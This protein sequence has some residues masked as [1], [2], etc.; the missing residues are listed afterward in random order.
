MFR[1]LDRYVLR[2]FIGPFVLASL[3]AVGIYA[4]IET[5]EKLEDVLQNYSGFTEVVA[6]LSRYHLYRLPILMPKLAYAITMI[7]VA[8][9]LVRLARHNELLAMKALGLNLQ[10]VVLPLVVA[11]FVIALS[12]GVL[13]EAMLPHVAGKIRDTDMKGGSEDDPH[14]YRDVMVRDSRG[15]VLVVQTYHSKQ[16]EF[17]DAEWMEANR[18]ENQQ[19]VTRVKSGRYDRYNKV[20]LM[21][22]ARQFRIGRGLKTVPFTDEIWE[23]DLMPRHFTE[24][25]V[26]FELVTTGKLFEMAGQIPGLERKLW[27][28]IH[29]RFAF[30]FTI[31]ALVLVGLPFVV[32]D[33]VHGAMLGVGVAVLICVLFYGI[34][35]MLIDLGERSPLG[36]PP[37]LPGWGSTGLFTALGIYQFRRIG[38]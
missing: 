11:S 14:V 2:T 29:S 18:P 28:L 9:A 10:R 35:I 13:Q 3:F 31:V 20:W 16:H 15:N 4:I 24:K 36:L 17:A 6:F 33:D 32:R 27:V 34:H 12:L 1:R 30:P 22:G 8:I 26:I 25:R 38:K 37:W 21:T 5:A 23:T 7:A 19:V